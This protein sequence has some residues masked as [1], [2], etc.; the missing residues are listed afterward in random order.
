MIDSAVQRDLLEEVVEEFAARC[1]RGETPSV[2]EYAARFPQHAGEIEQLLPTVAMMERLRGE[3]T[4]SR[5][6]AAQRAVA[7]SPPDHL[8]DFD[9][10]REVG[11]GGMGT[12]YEAVQ[13]SLARRV[14][15][16]VL[17][18][19]LLSRDRH[20]DRFRREAQTA[21]RLHHPNIVAVFGVGQQDGMHYYVMPLVR[22]VG[23]DEVVRELR[24]DRDPDLHGVVRGLTERK[25]GSGDTAA[26][27]FRGEKPRT[28]WQAVARIGVQA[29]EA[30]HF[31]HEQG[32]LH[33]DVK[34]GNLLIDA[35]GV[36]RVADFGLA[37]AV[38]RHDP[39]RP[40]EVVGTRRYMAPEQWQG[41]ADARTDVY[42]LGLTLYEL[43]TLRPAQENSEARGADGGQAGD[44]PPRPREIDVAVPRDLEAV[45]LRCIAPDPAQRYP[46][47]AAVAEDLRR[48]L[49]DRPVRARSVSLVQRLGR[50]C[51]RNPALAAT[52]ALAAVLLVAVAATAIAGYVQTRRAFAETTEALDR[53]RATS[54]LARDVLNDIYLQL[55]P[56]RARIAFDPDAGNACACIG[57]RTGAPATTSAGAAP[58]HVRASPETAAVLANLIGFYDRLAQ[59]VSGDWQLKLD[60][61]IASRRVGDIRQRLGQMDQAELAY[62]NA[63][64]TLITLCGRAEDD[65]AV[66][67][68]MAR[69]YNEIGS[70]ESARGQH[71]RACLSHRTALAVLRTVAAAEALP[72]ELRFERA[73]TLYF[74]ASKLPTA[75]LSAR[76]SAARGTAGADARKSQRLQG[77]RCRRD[78]VRILD[79]LVQENPSAPDYRFLLALCHRPLGAGPESVRSPA[80]QRGRR[81]AIQILEELVAQHPDVADYRYELAATYAW[82]P[83]NLLSS[84]GR[85]A[86]SAEFEHGLRRA[87][88]QAEWLVAHDSANPH[89][90]RSQ[91]LILAKLGTVSWK[92]RRLDEAETCFR[93]AIKLKEKS[94]AADPNLPSHDRVFLELVRWRL[95]QVLQQA[96]STE[97]A[98]EARAE[99]RSL[100][101][102]CV[103]NLR[104]LSERPELAGDRLCATTLRSAQAA[105]G[106]LKG[107]SS[108]A[109]LAGGAGQAEEAFP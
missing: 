39:D 89:Y 25:F 95:S 83:L 11:R 100:L 94:L 84:P 72:A 56:D 80:S 61:A 35:E 104:E 52:S 105:L 79:E 42:G 71:G 98:A 64:E 73:R 40:R 82:L 7:E 62:L 74:L 53:A 31:A 75:P 43:L 12:V 24:R 65:L 45:V 60:S 67:T 41:G 49:A 6:A 86:L 2:A 29:A 47:A 5:Q 28:C 44:R 48:F 81:R 108:H 36:V 16:K 103:E 109:G 38:D 19:N 34:P 66:A 77:N 15:V 101:K 57:L 91:A 3:E 76:E 106:R 4:A 37:R 102:T 22:G 20:L 50:W 55:A 18:S 58:T 51:R 14:A 70:V 13:R 21:A 107:P 85:F 99:S 78:A 63:V 46:T 97:G 8:G 96:G 69:S 92:A 23:L 27:R 33:R 32:T 54:R 9:I 88:R 59:Q 93:D 87:L 17:P 30:L 68:E 90:A 1:R 26:P 10:L